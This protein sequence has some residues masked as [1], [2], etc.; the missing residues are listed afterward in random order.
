M[1]TR[2][3]VAATL[4]VAIAL[5]AGL[6]AADIAA[7]PETSHW[8]APAAGESPRPEGQPADAGEK[9]DEPVAEAP[10]YAAVVITDYAG[11]SRRRIVGLADTK[12]TPPPE[13]LPIL[14]KEMA[15]YNQA[16]KD[17]NE[18]KKASIAARPRAAALP[19]PPPRP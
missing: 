11:K 8:N 5:G 13:F 4:G 17:W 1:T 3:G 14:D 9:V 15:A 19:D 7:A 2:A 6:W 18:K 12:V 10:Y 16:V